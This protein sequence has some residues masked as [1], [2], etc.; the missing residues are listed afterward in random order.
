MGAGQ[1]N[2]KAAKLP[3]GAIIATLLDAVN[4]LSQQGPFQ[5]LQCAVLQFD[6]ADGIATSTRGL[7][8]RTAALN[9][10]G[11]GALNLR[12]EQI[13]LRFKT[14]KRKGFGFNLLGIADRFIYIN[15]TV[16]K[17]HIAVDPGQ[18]LIDGGA[19]WAT[20]GLSILCD[21]LL[22]RLTAFNDPCET[23][24]RRGERRSR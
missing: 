13:L 2:N 18:L 1:F 12:T 21:Q 14:A 5:A 23:V 22:T 6:I 9:V 8:L 16:R 11:S 15:G 10:L 24:L 19:A 17:P 4:P 20:F 3:F 7:A